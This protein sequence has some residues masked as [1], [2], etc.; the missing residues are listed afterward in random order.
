MITYWRYCDVLLFNHSTQNAYMPQSR[1]R[2]VIRML[3]CTPVFHVGVISDDV[4][5]WLCASEQVT[6]S[7]CEL[8]IY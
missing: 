8:Y 4:V 5:V 7:E 1:S 3:E 2:K 6:R